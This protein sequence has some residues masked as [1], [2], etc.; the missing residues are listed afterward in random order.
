[1]KLISKKKKRL[2]FLLT[3][4][5]I[6]QC[7]MISGKADY[8][9]AAA[10]PYSKIATPK[11]STYRYI[12]KTYSTSSTK[13]GK[14]YKGSG[15]TILKT[16]TTWLKV[17]SGSVTGYIK[18]ANVASGT[19]LETYAK[20]NNFPKKL[21]VNVN[22]LI[23]RAKASKTASIVTGISKGETYKM[24]SE[25][26]KW[27]KISTEDGTGYVSKE[28]VTCSYALTDA[29]KITAASSSSSSTSKSSS[30]AYS[31]V[32]LCT[33]DSLRVRKSGS[34]SAQIVGYMNPKTSATIL[35]KGSSW[36]K[37][38][39][40]TV[41]GY[42]KNNY[43]VTGSKVPTYASK[44]GVTEKVTLKTALNVRSAAST[45]S[46]KIGGAS[47]GSSYTL[48]KEFTNWV[49]IAYGSKTGYLKKSYVTIA[50]D[51]ETA[52]PVSQSSSS[53]DTSSGSG[54]ATGSNIVNYA[55]QFKGNPYVY[56]GTSLTNG[57]DCSG[58]TQAIY[59]HFGYTISRVSRDQANNGTSVSLSSL[60]KGDLIFYANTSGTIN[61]V[62]IYIGNSQVIHAS[63]EKVGIIVS[64]YTYRTPVKAV[65]IIK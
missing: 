61:H 43:Y 13:V 52:V 2:F 8:C 37:I 12:F 18:K 57:C 45:S 59:S 62:A 34:T 30:S 17:K 25:T 42:I 14:L 3:S 29:V 53:S 56:G 9:E 39:S 27:A 24:I 11:T 22:S 47:K 64:T 65:R 16:G 32:A 46:K 50:Y 21:T 51:F 1:M 31:K 48:K 6:L 26:T 38:Q 4:L 41:I 7:F 28:Y 15:A 19:K 10:S 33:A 35:S 44:A 58:F 5:L 36:T 40:G 20:K 63:N 54:S 49:S 23:V 60:Q 55:L